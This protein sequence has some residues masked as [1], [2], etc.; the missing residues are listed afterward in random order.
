MSGV[1]NKV[2][3]RAEPQHSE[4]LTALLTS[5]ASDRAPQRSRWRS[6]TTCRRWSGW[7]WSRTLWTPTPRLPC[8][9]PT[10]LT[11]WPRRRAEGARLARKLE[12]CWM[13]VQMICPG[14]VF[15]IEIRAIIYYFYWFKNI[16]LETFQSVWIDSVRWSSAQGWLFSLQ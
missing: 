15:R 1:A 16:S 6:C 10:S 14:W 5:A 3:T 7:T 2:L 12:N 8:S 11:F 9:L 4:P 13:M